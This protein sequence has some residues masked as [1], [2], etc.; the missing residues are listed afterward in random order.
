MLGLDYFFK[1]QPLPSPLEIQ[2]PLQHQT[3]L[4][5]P[6]DAAAFV[7]SS[8]Q[9]SDLRVI[10]VLCRISRLANISPEPF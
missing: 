4:Y 2:R 7:G 6:F 3:D 10:W 8:S 5:L 1:E 9:S